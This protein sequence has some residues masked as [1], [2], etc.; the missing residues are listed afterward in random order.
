MKVASFD[1]GIKHLAYCIIDTENDEIKILNWDVINLLENKCKKCDKCNFCDKLP[2]YY[3]DSLNSC[4]QH[5]NKLNDKPI[6]YYTIKNTTL[7]EIGYLL[8]TTLDKI[9]FN[10]CDYIIL[11]SQP[12]IFISSFSV[13]II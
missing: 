11:E 4:Y 5:R 8:V 6:R 12:K 3:C 9:N 7:A 1:I 10:D 2:Y 13:S